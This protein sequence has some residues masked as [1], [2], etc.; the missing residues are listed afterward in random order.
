[1]PNNPT[2]TTLVDLARADLSIVHAKK[3]IRSLIQESKNLADKVQNAEHHLK[4]SERAL[5]LLRQSEIETQQK[6]ESYR[7]RKQTAVRALEKGPF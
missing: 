1:M 2:V 7:K 5:S 3:E 4:S 6:L